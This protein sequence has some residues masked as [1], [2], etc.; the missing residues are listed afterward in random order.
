MYNI[1][2]VSNNILS[3]IWFSYHKLQIELPVILGQFL[4]SANSLC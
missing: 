2:S 4:D 1:K 3:Q